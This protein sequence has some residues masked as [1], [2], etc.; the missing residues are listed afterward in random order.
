MTAMPVELPN[1]HTGG[2]MTSSSIRVTASGTR[3]GTKLLVAL[4]CVITSSGCRDGL[5]AVSPRAKT[6]RLVAPTVKSALA[7]HRS[8][9]IPDE[10][11]VVF[12]N[13]VTDPHGRADALARATGATLRYT[14]SHSI[15]GFAAHMSE[16]AAAAIAQHPGVAFVEEDREATASDTEVNA[17]WGLD[18]IDQSSLPLDGTYS[19]STTGAGVNVYI[20]DTGIRTTHSQFGGRAKAAFTSMNDGYGAEGCHWHGT[21]VA[22]TVAGSTVGV[23][24]NATVYSVRVLDCSGS[25]TVSGVIA[26]VDWVTANRI[27]PAVANMS[28]S[29]EFSQALNDAVKRAIANGITFTVAA[30]NSA[31]D[32]CGFSP[33]SATGALTVGATTIAD[34]MAWFSNW[35]SCVDVFAPGTSITSAMNA[36]DYTLGSANGTSMAAPHVAG[37]A[38]L[39]LETHPGASPADVAADILGNATSGAVIGA[40][41]SPNLL[42]HVNGAG[43]IVTPPPPTTTVPP[44]PPNSPPSAM[45]SASCQKSNCRF[46]AS[47]SSD[48]T[49]ITSYKWSFGDGSSSVS[50][51]SPLAAHSYA[52]RGSYSVSVVLTVTDSYGA[53]ASVT[54]SISIKNTG[55]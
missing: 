50:A 12:D 42:L 55:K 31:V 51:S 15:N 23:A 27:L 5:S 9:P 6:A 47:S 19:H 11:I 38:A 17:I 24:K 53:S 36:D 22:G 29:S 21:H 45:F 28:L 43:G 14:Y 25:G 2:K 39:Y 8:D 16:Q 18:R 40:Q 3:N 7:Q 26:G 48:D 54:R 52:Q 4:F 37:A 20:I 34:G 33:S 49:G 32:A 41:S 1:E 44:P 10:Y 13:S 46:D 30:G 35:G